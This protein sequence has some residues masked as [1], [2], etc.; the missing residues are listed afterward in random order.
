MPEIT[1]L[2]AP[3]HAA[4]T[5]L[6]RAYNATF[7]TNIPDDGYTQAWHRLVEAQEVRGIAARVDGE[8]VGIA[9]YRHQPSVWSVGTLYLQDLYVVPESRKQG[10]ARAMIEWLAQEAESHGATS[11]YWHTHDSNTT[12]RAF[13]DKVAVYRG[14][15]TYNRP[16]AT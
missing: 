16:L 9:H 15:I 14:F 1:P 3:D 13:Y 5:V 11:F 4:W 7:G 2:T 10:V 6:A 12:A 8:M